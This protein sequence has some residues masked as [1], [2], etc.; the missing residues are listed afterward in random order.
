MREVDASEAKAKLSS[1][2]DEVERGETILIR[3]RGRPIARVVPEPRR[4]Q[5]EIDR[6]VE[7]IKQLRKHTGKVT[8]EEILAWRHEGHK[9]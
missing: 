8:V 7:E 6:A 1:L 3:R 4:R 2:L 5:D 9:Y